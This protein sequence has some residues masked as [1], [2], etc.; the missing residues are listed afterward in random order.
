MI[1][2]SFDFVIFFI[3]VVFLYYTIPQKFRWIMLLT[4]SCIFYMCWRAELIILLLFSTF[5]NWGISLLIDK[6][7]EKKKGLLILS[8]VINFGL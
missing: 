8:L 6:N 1:F 3:I 4:A 2:N 7:R 5:T